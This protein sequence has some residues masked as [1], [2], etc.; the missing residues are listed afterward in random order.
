[1]AVVRVRIVIGRRL[2]GMAV[3]SPAVCRR[4][5]WTAFPVAQRQSG[6]SMDAWFA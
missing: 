5:V 4:N 6:S 1:V 2:S 3:P